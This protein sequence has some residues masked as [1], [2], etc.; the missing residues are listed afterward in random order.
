M[1]EH[2]PPIAR[3]EAADRIGRITLGAAHDL[4]VALAE[5]GSTE[6]EPV[7]V[8]TGGPHRTLDGLV[9][10]I[11]EALAEDAASADEDRRGTADRTP[12]SPT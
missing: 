11:D 12:Q 5:S 6:S 3:H 2:P 8:R 9:A 4:G 1:D 7:V 10:L